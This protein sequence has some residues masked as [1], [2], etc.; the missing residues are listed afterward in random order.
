MQREETDRRIDNAGK[1]A[2]KLLLIAQRADDQE[3]IKLLHEL[4]GQLGLIKN[5]VRF[6]RRDKEKSS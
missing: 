1:T 5:S 4:L 3:S 6:E 2:G